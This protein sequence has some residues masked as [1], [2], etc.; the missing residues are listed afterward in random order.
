[1]MTYISISDVRTAGGFPSDLASDSDVE[2]AIEIVEKNVE[3]AMNTKF[4]PTLKIDIKT[5]EK[6]PFIYTDKFPI[7]RLEEVYVDE[8][9]DLSDLEIHDYSGRISLISGSNIS[10]F[11]S[12]SNNVRIKYFYGLME[13]ENDYTFL[14]GDYNA[15][16]TEIDVL[17]GSIFS[18][19]DWV[20]IKGLDGN[21]EFVQ[22][23][24]ISSNTLTIT[25]TIFSHDD[26][27]LVQ[28]YEIPSYVKRF[29]ELEAVIYLAI[30]AIGATYVF[31]AGYSLGDLNVQKG[32]PYTH[33]NAA[34]DKCF[35]EREI[36]RNRIKPRMR[37][38]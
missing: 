13:A 9:L 19:D 35:K 7:L 27:S 31:N 6:L 12:E 16:V 36:L 34:Y 32:V 20:S 3:R 38:M 33:W 15:G 5:G 37:V 26:E 30:N 24:S 8:S 21:S 23:E 1:M 4:S 28:K 29:M 2:H 18:D 11:D 25:E 10:V 17:D 22:I 14:D